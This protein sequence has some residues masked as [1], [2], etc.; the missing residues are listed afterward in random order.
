MKPD[1]L[2]TV[3]DLRVDFVGDRTVPAVAGISYELQRGETLAI[4]GESGSGKSSAALALVGLLPEETV[5]MSGS[6]NFD[7][8]E[9]VGATDRLLSTIRG[10]RIGVV[11]QDPLSS[12][13]PVLSVG[14]QVTEVLE[15][16]LGMTPKAA[17]LRATE[18][19]DIVGLPD[20]AAV[21]QQYPHQLSGGMRQRVM[22]AAALACQPS[23]L[24]AD[25]PTTALDVTIEAQ[26][27]S[28]LRSLRAEFGMAILLISHDIGVVAGIADRLA[29]MYAGR[30]VEIGPVD[31]VL[32]E[33]THP[34]TTALLRSLPGV[35]RQSAHRLPTIKGSPPDLSTLGPGC[36]FAPRCEHTQ[37]RCLLKRPR[38]EPV[39]DRPLSDAACWVM[40]A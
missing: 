27:L 25:E 6:V 15:V 36:S 11:F 8:H 13:N 40:N 26:I 30:F 2:V 24:I 33:P 21:R 34:Y 37:D 14:R 23:L 7:G 5:K 39:K 29:V 31:D 32:V 10:R 19:L 22:L 35:D 20:A 12:L 17:K 3:S 16:H 1:P 9:L 28:L 18:L 38:L 4:V